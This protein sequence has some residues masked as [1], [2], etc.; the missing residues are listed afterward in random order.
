MK[1]PRGVARLREE[2]A[3]SIGTLIVNEDLIKQSGDKAE[4]KKFAKV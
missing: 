1:T 3:V 2:L 4:V